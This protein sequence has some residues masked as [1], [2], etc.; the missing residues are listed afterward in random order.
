MRL[1]MWGE[2][3]RERVATRVALRVVAGSAVRLQGPVRVVGSDVDRD[4]GV[5]AVRVVWRPGSAR[6][7]REHVEL[8]Q[9]VDGEWR[10][11]GGGSGPAEA[12]PGTVEVLEV[13]GGSGVRSFGSTAGP[14]GWIGCATIRVGPDVAYVLVGARRHT[15]TTTGELTTVWTSPHHPQ[16]GTRPLIVAL[17]HEGTE[18]SRL[19]PDDVLDSHTRRRLTEEE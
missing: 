12:A 18:L 13:G 1:R 10:V 16:G 7:A 3:L 8:L 5:A 9:R 15:P 4:E 19:G 14:A 2:V 11:R 17:D 6:A